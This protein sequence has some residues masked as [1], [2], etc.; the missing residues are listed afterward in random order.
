[1]NNNKPIILEIEEAKT[2]IIQ[3]I[4]KAIQIRHIP[5]YLVDMLLTDM[6]AQ[7]K[8]GARNELEMAKEQMNKQSNEGVAESTPL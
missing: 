7:L 3:A 4:N 2:E 5:C 6:R 8:E 1:M